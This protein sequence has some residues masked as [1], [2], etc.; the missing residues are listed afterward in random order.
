MC[1]RMCVPHRE[2][3][4]RVCLLCLKVRVVLVKQTNLSLGALWDTT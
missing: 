3:R 4:V 2:C 1:T